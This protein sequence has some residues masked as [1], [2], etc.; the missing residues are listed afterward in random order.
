[1]TKIILTTALLALTAAPLAYAQ[2]GLPTQTLVQEDSKN[3]TPLTP[4]NLTLKIQ[5]H[6]VPITSVAPV[7]PQNA[8]VALLI[9][10]GVRGSF[11]RNGDDIRNFITGL[12]SGTEVLLGYMQNG[13]VV[14]AAPF[15]T[16]HA[17]VAQQVRLPF[18]QPGMS[19]SPYF[20]LS[21]FVKSWP[22]AETSAPRNPEAITPIN[23]GAPVHKA[24][25]VLMITNGVDPYN[26]S[27]SI[28][29][30]DSPNVATAIRDAQRAGVAVYSVYYPDAGFGMRRGSATL[31]GQSYLSQVAD[32]TGGT[33]YYEGSGSPVS[34]IPYFKQFVDA[35][36][37]T[38]IATFPS[39][40]KDLVN[41]KL[42]TNLPKTKLHHSDEVRPGTQLSN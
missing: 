39:E 5:N 9:D 4:S 29:N 32:S 15:S 17:A 34:L 38:Y 11:G 1:M 6:P 27:T 40:G 24:R 18:G 20:C 22:G 21:D 10:D 31:S 41:I 7:T 37:Q 36:G 25:F 8:Q 12:P 33:T 23:T 2:E 35:V 16:D 3:P 30:Q 14:V 28:L 42:S 26:G 13:R 19:S